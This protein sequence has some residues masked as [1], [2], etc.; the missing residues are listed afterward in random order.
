[1]NII[2]HGFKIENDIIVDYPDYLKYDGLWYKIWETKN[3]NGSF[4]MHRQSIKYYNN[5]IGDYLRFLYDNDEKQ[6]I[7]IET[8]TGCICI[9]SEIF[10]FYSKKEYIK[11]R[12]LV[13]ESEKSDLEKE[14]KELNLPKVGKIYDLILYNGEILKN[15]L[16]TDIDQFY[17]DTI[18]V[19]D[20]II[21]QAYSNIDD[22]NQFIH[23]PE[24]D[25]MAKQIFAF[26]ELGKED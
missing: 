10:K 21:R 2:E 13:I 9:D 20:S 22:I 8:S 17:V 12:L 3:Y 15:V 23:K 19:V 16:V 18:N 7:E 25:E 4:G 1:M 24:Y 26:I 6:I 11:E 14:L 5:D